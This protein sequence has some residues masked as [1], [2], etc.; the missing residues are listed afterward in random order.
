MK[1]QTNRS[2][3]F[4]RLLT[5]LVVLAF[6]LA[7]GVASRMVFAAGEAR[8]ITV[9]IVGSFQSELGCSY[10]WQPDCSTTALF[11]NAEDRV[12]QG[13]FSLPAGN[14]E[15]KAA[16][17]GSITETYG[18]NAQMNGDSL[19][20]N[21]SAASAVKFYFNHLT[22]WVTSSQNAVIANVPG[23]FQN[24]L[25]CSNDWQPD[26][27]RTWLQDPDGDQIYEFTTD[28]IEAGNYEAKVALNESWDINFG[29]NGVQSGNNIPFSIQNSC[30]R[31]R[32]TYDS[33]TH[34]L[35]VQPDP[36]A[37][38]QP[39]SVTIVGSFQQY[40][41]CSD[42]WQPGCAVTSLT[43]DAQDDVWQGSFFIP[44]AGN[45]EYKVALNGTWDENY[46]ANAGYWG[47]NISISLSEPTTVK[48]Y[49]SHA[50]HWVVDN[51]SKPIYTVSGSFQ[52]ELGCS[53]DFQPDCLRSWLQ[54]PDGDG[55]YSFTNNKLPAG[56]Y[57]VKV[58][59]SESLSVYY[60]AGGVQNGPNIQFTVPGYC[61]PTNLQF[62]GGTHILAVES[63]DSTPLP[64][65]SIETRVNGEDA[66]V[67]PGPNLPSGSVLA[68]SYAIINTGEVALTGV[69]VVDDQGLVVSCPKTALQSGEFMTCTAT[70]SAQVGEHSHVGNVTANPPAGAQVSASDP[71]VYSGLLDT[72]SPETVLESTP[73]DPSYG[74]VTFTFSSEAG[75]T[76][77]CALDGLEF[78]ACTSPI[79]YTGLVAGSHTFHVRAK[80]AA[81]N[82]DLTQA[83]YTWTVEQTPNALPILTT[84]VQASV[85]AGSS[86]LI[87]TLTGS[88]F[89][90]GSTVRWNGA[91]L[92][93]TFNCATQL[94][95]TI[96]AINLSA[97]Q[98]ALVTV[99]TP[100][101]GGGTSNVLAFFVTEATAGVIGQ[102]VSSGTDPSA[103]SGLATATA[104]GDGLLVVAE[105]NAN[106]GGMP[107]FSASG[108][109][110]DV[111]AA[112]DNSF[113]QVSIAACGLNPNDKLFYWDANLGK[114][115]KASPQAYDSGTG[116]VTLTVTEVSSPSLSQLQ[117]TFF[118][119]GNIPPV[120]E[121]GEPYLGAVNTAI[122]FNGSNSSDPDGD[123][124]TYAWT[125]GD[126]ATGASIMPT[127][128]YAAAGIY[129]VC[130]TVSDSALDSNPD[131]TIAVVYDPDGGFVTGGGWIYSPAGAYTADPSLTGRATFGFIAK[132]QKGATIPD[133]N[134]A[135]QFTAGDLR[136]QSTNYQW[137]V[138]AGT[139]AQFK[140]VGTIN[141]EGCYQFMLTADDG[142]PDTF[143]IKIWYEVDGVEV[144]VYDNG[145]QQALG[146][147]S[148][149]VHNK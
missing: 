10:D 2:I 54:D 74:D 11:Y 66:D 29:A 124:L 129:D 16:L 31:T 132:Y 149:V 93:T 119:L 145:S 44:E 131:C 118:A 72:T 64:G 108:T 138:V 71:A 87:L 111:Y 92:D 7:A 75:A 133:G 125:F 81:G 14:W 23:S 106:P 123:L 76:F 141:G 79:V 135:F 30:D 26:C 59:T 43:Y 12:W 38:P 51:L 33:T 18:Q 22:H 130:L 142:S 55:V 121:A 98:T 57:Q 36:I 83:S 139:R 45:Y 146:G 19:Y 41:G 13:A 42:P 82:V 97:V 37:T 86:N 32:F 40:V 35:D 134:T 27:L 50:T 136:F 113:S 73:A 28:R 6:I 143:R 21:L 3:L 70:G 120:A 4:H 112:P 62:D 88:S 137:L 116:C 85:P 128:N 53:G 99:Y 103:A 89:I 95:A 100:E 52:S 20:L 107:S 63:M 46:G 109:Y 15:Y 140:G 78:S 122:Q 47:A 101:P 48:F 114:W 127:H 9:V 148:I 84:L 56:T 147:G 61:T 104:S 77:E 5:L 144:V 69:S 115:V 105:Y 102:E 117:G 58:A 49:Y 34:V 39:D 8:P 67:L 60:G 17:N 65:I 68:M 96:P 90:P 80:D 91:D 25:G 94:T 110:F 1:T 126:G 24:S